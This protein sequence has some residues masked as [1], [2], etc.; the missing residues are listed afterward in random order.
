MFIPY[1]LSYGMLLPT[2]IS[3]SLQMSDIYY[4]SVLASILILKIG[5]DKYIEKQKSCFSLSVSPPSY[6]DYLTYPLV[7]LMVPLT[8]YEAS[9]TERGRRS[10]LTELVK[11][12]F[13]WGIGYLGMWFGKWAI[14]TLLTSVNVFDGCR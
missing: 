7:A 14:A 8:I 2:V 12:S 10:Q 5:G 1:L 11:G 13:G 6:F 3:Q 4:I 9:I